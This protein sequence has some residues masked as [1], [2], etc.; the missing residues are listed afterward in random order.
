MFDSVAALSSLY[1]N[2]LEHA[3]RHFHSEDVLRFPGRRI[4]VKFKGEVKSNTK[5]RVEGTRVKHRVG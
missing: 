5:G 1:P 3:V 2:L 4:N